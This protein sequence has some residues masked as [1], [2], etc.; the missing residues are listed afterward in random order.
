LVTLLGVYFALGLMPPI[1]ALEPAQGRLGTRS[2]ALVLPEELPQAFIDRGF[3]ERFMAA[4]SRSASRHAARGHTPAGIEV[5]VLLRRE[6]A[7][8]P[9]SL[10]SQIAEAVRPTLRARQG[11][12]VYENDGY[13]VFSSWDDEDDSTWEGNVFVYHY[14]TGRSLSIDAQLDVS[15]DGE[16]APPIEWAEGDLEGGEED[17]EPGPHP[18]WAPGFIQVRPFVSQASYRAEASRFERAPSTRA[19]CDCELLQEPGHEV[20]DCMLWNALHDSWWVCGGAA[21]GC[22]FSGPAY[23]K[24]LGGSCLA[25]FVANFLEELDE[26]YEE[27]V[28]MADEDEVLGTM[29]AG[30]VRGCQ[31]TIG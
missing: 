26:F 20:A 16:E 17:E 30:L 24:C 11:E 7:Q 18:I 23:F 10:L 8:A 22:V 9:T 3:D 31:L 27:C 14:A 4:Q 2:A 13:G 1:D 25:A 15:G 28:A 12:T 21:A 19:A 6:R 29:A 5:G